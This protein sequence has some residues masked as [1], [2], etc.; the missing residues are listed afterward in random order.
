M[1]ALFVFGRLLPFQSYLLANT[2]SY[3]GNMAA[4]VPYSRPRCID[5]PPKLSP[6]FIPARLHFNYVAEA[7]GAGVVPVEQ[8]FF[9]LNIV[10]MK[11]Y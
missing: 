3:P 7:N 6:S 9:F 5:F 4:A 2:K 1:L 10:M 11:F 8:V